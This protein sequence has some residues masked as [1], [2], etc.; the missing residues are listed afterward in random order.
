VERSID[1]DTSQPRLKSSSSRSSK[2][3]LLS[4]SED[5]EKC[6]GENKKSEHIKRSNLKTF[7]SLK[8]SATQSR[9]SNSKTVKNTSEN[10]IAKTK[11]TGNSNQLLRS[12]RSRSAV[13]TVSAASVSFKTVPT[14]V[15]DNIVV[16]KKRARYEYL[17]AGRETTISNE[18]TGSGCKAPNLGARLARSGRDAPEQQQQQDIAS[19]STSSLQQTGHPPQ[20][21]LRR[22]SRGK[23]SSF[24]ESK[25]GSCVSIFNIFFKFF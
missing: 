8:V 23:G 5:K 16:P 11:Q 7:K 13:E 6:K 22:S 18:R 20:N 19:N 25:T 24:S 17:Q 15:V 14:S 10:S 9:L 2:S 12:L 4:E 21:L 3:Q 1:L